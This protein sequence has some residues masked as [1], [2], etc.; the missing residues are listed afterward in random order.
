MSM[1]VG[2]LDHYN[3]STRNL[4]DTVRFYEEV[5][6]L[7]NGPRPPFDFPGAWLYSE[8]HPVLHLNDISP[9]DK[10]QRPDSGVIDHIAFGSR[11]FDAIKQHL[12]GK[13]VPFR[14]NEVPNSS[15]RQ[16]FLTDPNNV[17][18]ELNF[19]VA[20]ETPAR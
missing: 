2:M 10:P 13:G 4:R 5:L 9:T 7:V 19:D 6:G 11:G 16:I 12:T 3:V 15:R 8:G 1:S 17:L 20:K 18:I 14:V